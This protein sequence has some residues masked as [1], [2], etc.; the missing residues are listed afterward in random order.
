MYIP[1]TPSQLRASQGLSN[2]EVVV[3]RMPDL[4]APG[5]AVVDIQGPPGEVQW[6][7]ELGTLRVSGVAGH[8]TNN[9]RNRRGGVLW[10][11]AVVT[12]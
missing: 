10:Q 5:Y 2:D 12:F 3:I 9:N 6:N 7:G 11:L 8:A 4:V 1:A